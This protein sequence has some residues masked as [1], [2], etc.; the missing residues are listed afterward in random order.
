MNG[1]T[2][3][4]IRGLRTPD[5]A[6]R[7]V[8][9]W[10]WNGPVTKAGIEEQLALLK[11]QNITDF[12]I[13]PAEGMELEYLSDEFMEMVVHAV[14]FAKANGMHYW[15]YDEYNW[16]SGVAGEKVL[17]DHPEYHCRILSEETTRVYPEA[18][19]VL[20][21]D[22]FLGAQVVRVDDPAEA[23]I[24]V[25]DA[26]RIIGSKCFWK[27][28]T[29][30]EVV[31]H[32]QSSKHH[33]R[34]WPFAVG[35]RSSHATPGY[36]DLTNAAATRCFIQYTH[37]RYR[38]FLGEEFGRTVLGVFT[39][40]PGF[41]WKCYPV[42]DALIAG[43]AAIYGS[44][45]P[46]LLHL[47][48]KEN[49]ERAIAFRR[50]YY[51]VLHRLMLEN[52]L[53]VTSRW[54]EA[55]H[56]LFTGH[57]NGEESLLTNLND[58]ET[59]PRLRSFGVPGVDLIW[60]TVR[61]F[62]P[63]FNTLCATIANVSHFSGKERLL[64]ETFTLST[65]SLTMQHM[66]RVASRI[67]ASGVNMLQFMGCHYSFAG[68]KTSHPGP[69]NGVHNVLFPYY[70][71]FN[72]YVARLSCLSAATVPYAKV[73]VLQPLTAAY[74]HGVQYEYPAGAGH[75]HISR[76]HVAQVAD[77]LNGVVNAL[78]KR[79]IGFEMLYESQLLE[80]GVY[81]RDGRLCVP[82]PAPL[83]ASAVPN[84]YAV[85]VLPMA[86]YTRGRTRQL[87]EQFVREGGHLILVG[88]VPLKDIDDFVPYALG[89]LAEVAGVAA[90]LRRGE[91]AG[92]R[93][94]RLA[95]APGV[96]AV[97][98]NQLEIT[99]DGFSDAL[100]ACVAATGIVPDIEIRAPYGVFSIQ[101]RDA[102]GVDYFLIT[103][104][105]TDPAQVEVRVNTGK[106][107]LW[108][109]VENSQV[110]CTFER[111]AR[112]ALPP[113]V[114]R[115]V[116]SADETALASFRSAFP[117]APTYTREE[118]LP[119][120][121]FRF[122]ALAPNALRLDFQRYQDSRA[123]ADASDAAR[124]SALAAAPAA[125][126][127]SPAFPENS[128]Y[129]ARAVFRAEAVPAGLRLETER[130]F[131]QRLFCNGTELVGGR[132][133][134]RLG[135]PCTVYEVA[136]LV[137]A[138]MNTLVAVGRSSSIRRS[139]SVP[140]AMLTGDFLLDREHTLVAK[141]DLPCPGDWTA[142]GYPQYG[143]TGRYEV[144]IEVR[145][146]PPAAIRFETADSV[147]LWLDGKPVG[148]KMGAP[149]VFPLAG[150]TAG[151]H[152]LRADVTGTLHNLYYGTVAPRPAGQ[153]N[154]GTLPAGITGA[155]LLYEGRSRRS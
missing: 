144:D 98:S 91:W 105:L 80:D 53:A 87:L 119:L 54:C 60:I 14:R 29:G 35:C 132:D 4:A 151:R 89:D 32:V 88:D 27:N 142:A 6:Y 33:D 106:P 107:C 31:L 109:D 104:N 97:V 102:A 150:L 70:H 117:S 114:C 30:A 15:I 78:T 79:H 90:A 16:P 110:V 11:G 7:P 20:P 58:G 64:C 37:E 71:L 36:V 136:A 148:Q 81:V 65:W 21:V 145:D 155:A 124:W 57:L 92:K 67:V 82:N 101:R 118:P 130:L 19:G 96:Q 112:L 153:H 59:L 140:F 24:D 139:Y 129:A 100:A 23:S 76:S 93:T 68:I 18:L 75:A 111:E 137:K 116:V 113:C 122:T 149:Y 152:R 103:S 39:D 5:G 83:G 73:M 154:G 46:R 28:T 133:E 134:Q 10:F 125:A 47:L 49:G 50:D 120:A 121:A 52:F 2:E 85:V 34:V 128:F 126:F 108:L 115:V 69:D 99:E 38:A 86:R 45:T 127:G 51:A 40:E 141:T 55:N 22:I 84:A 135:E 8:M 41:M 42:S 146:D 94:V 147:T 138:G 25:T 43:L 66:R 61:M 131:G 77:S 123:L 12:F 17:I 143:G 26:C 62:W 72:D 3:S 74:E 95:P 13:H 48:L 1:S 44:A 63:D 56:L 9:M